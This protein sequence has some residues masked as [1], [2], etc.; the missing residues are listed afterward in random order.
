MFHADIKRMRR[1]IVK[2]K[3]HLLRGAGN[4]LRLIIDFFSHIVLGLT[5]I[6]SLAKGDFKFQIP[7][8]FSKVGCKQLYAA[9]NNKNKSSLDGEDR[10]RGKRNKSAWWELKKWR[11]STTLIWFSISGT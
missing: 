6:P 3:T 5:Q 10:L 4:S 1:L 9:L 11:N 8:P 7:S 2:T